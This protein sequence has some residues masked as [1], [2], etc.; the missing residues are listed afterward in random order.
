MERT[1]QKD[2]NVIEWKKTGG[3]SIRFIV[4]GRERMIKPGERFFAREDEIPAGFRDIIIPV[5][6]VARV[7]KLEEADAVAEVTAKPVYELKH[8]GGGWWD[9]VDADGKVQNEKALKKEEAADLLETL[10]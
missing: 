7:K 8:R 10:S 2:P 3:G 4:N 5:D 9:V 6:P 1:K